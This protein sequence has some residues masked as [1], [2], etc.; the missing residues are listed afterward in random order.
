MHTATRRKV[1]L[2]TQTKVATANHAT[3]ERER[4]VRILAK[5]IFRQLTANGYDSRHV[6]SLAAELIGE[7]TAELSSSD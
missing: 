4:G 5:S 2:A 6:V 1:I 3:S 7:V